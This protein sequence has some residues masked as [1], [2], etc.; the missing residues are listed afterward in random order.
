[1]LD[2]YR[3][4]LKDSDPYSSL[5]VMAMV[6]FND[7]LYL[8]NQCLL[9][10]LHFPRLPNSFRLA[11]RAGMFRQDALTLYQTQMDFQK[12]SLREILGSVPNLHI[13]NQHHL[14]AIERMLHQVAF[15][16]RSVSQPWSTILSSHMHK[17]ALG[18]LLSFCFDNFIKGLE[19]LRDITEKESRDLHQLLSRFKEFTA[20][21]KTRDPDEILDYIPSFRKFLLIV[22]ILEMNMADIMSL[23]RQGR[24]SDFSSIE[25]VNLIKALFAETPLRSTNL[26]EI[27]SASARSL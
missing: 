17:R 20:D 9:L 5:P 10:P 27:T 4:L 23:F 2:L 3:I 12:N 11:D 21:F 7:F 24:L 18:E 26:L 14:Q 19:E 8:Q 15:H 6:L 1:M 13:H 25:L 16:I 22:D